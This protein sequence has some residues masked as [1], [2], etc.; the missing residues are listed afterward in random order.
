MIRRGHVAVLFGILSTL[1]GLNASASQPP[2]GVNHAALTKADCS[3]CHTCPSPT[4]DSPCLK[5]C[6]RPRPTVDPDHRGPELIL[7][8]ELEDRY[9]SVPFDHK[10]HAEMAAMTRGCV[11]CHHY[12][13]QGSPHPACKTCHEVAGAR[14]D[15]QKPGLKGAYHRQCLNCHREW[16]DDTQC[17]TCH[18]AK[19]GAGRR[20]PVTAPPTPD[21]LVG[22]MHPPIPEPDTDIFTPRAGEQAGTKVIFYHKDHIHRFGLACVECHHEDNCNRCHNPAA[23]RPT[24]PTL[25]EHH[26]PCA[27]CHATTQPDRCADC[28]WKEGTPRPPRF[29]HARTAFLLKVYHESVGCRRCHAAVPFA[30]LERSCESCHKSWDAATFNHGVTGLTLDANHA[31]QTC[32][33]CHAEKRFDRPPT[34]TECHDAD[35]GIAYPAK[36]PG[37]KSN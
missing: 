17:E 8:R 18:Q 35:S 16:S 26:Q 31:G 24:E 28:H 6:P 27:T 29:D 32:E 12:T 10:G 9:L 4:K 14:A 5:E 7:L 22:R 37:A 36:S 25:S 33:A 11:V 23:P 34:C 1:A 21:D 30:K 13:P 2:N 3:L 19:T 15:V 20:K